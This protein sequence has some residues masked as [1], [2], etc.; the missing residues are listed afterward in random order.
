[1]NEH[2]DHPF[3]ERFTVQSEAG[4][5]AGMM[6]GAVAAVCAAVILIMITVKIGIILFA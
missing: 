5:T 2:D 1:M 4:S 6:F 3:E